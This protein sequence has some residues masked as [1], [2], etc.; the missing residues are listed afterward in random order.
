MKNRVCKPEI[1]PQGGEDTCMHAS[2]D[3]VVKTADRESTV[4]I[5]EGVK[6]VDKKAEISAQDTCNNLADNP[7]PDQ[8][9]SESE[10]T[11]RWSD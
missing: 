5:R 7:R 9:E 4:L 11:T 2:S 10:P 6:I 8:T 1:T 3:N